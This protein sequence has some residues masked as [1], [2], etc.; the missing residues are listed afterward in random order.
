MDEIVLDSKNPMFFILVRTNLFSDHARR[1]DAKMSRFFDQYYINT[2]DE[3]LV[4][5]FKKKEE[6][7]KHIWSN[8]NFE[9]Y[10]F[11]SLFKTTL[12]T[13]RRPDLDILQDLAREY[14][15]TVNHASQNPVKEHMKIKY[16]Y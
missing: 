13:I 9:H 4:E 10:F 14:I 3:D 2:K 16:L 11:G 12:P 6:N 15:A 1:K 8:L 5:L 7:Y